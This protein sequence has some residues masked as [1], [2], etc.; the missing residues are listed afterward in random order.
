MATLTALL[1]ASLMVRVTFDLRLL[2]KVSL[3]FYQFAVKVILVKRLWFDI[4]NY[5]RW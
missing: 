5:D 4:V 3:S 1:P 2:H